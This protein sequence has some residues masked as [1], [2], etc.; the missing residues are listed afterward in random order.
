MEHFNGILFHKSGPAKKQYTN[1]PTKTQ[2]LLFTYRIKSED[3]D[4]KY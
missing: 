4:F 1:Q 3:L 2:C